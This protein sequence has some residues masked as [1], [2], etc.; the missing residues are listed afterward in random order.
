MALV[1]ARSNIKVAGIASWGIS[2]TT[3]SDTGYSLIPYL[4]N[5]KVEIKTLQTNNSLGQPVP[6]GY[7]LSASAQFPAVKTTANFIKILHHLA[8]DQIEHKIT[9]I[10]G[11][12]ISS[13]PGTSTPSPTGFGTKWRI[14][15][16]KDMDGNMYTEI[17]I[18]RR[19]TAAEYTQILTTANAPATGTSAT[20]TN[21]LNLTRADIVPA[22]ISSV[23]L[24]AASAGTY[25]DVISNLRNGKFTAEL[26]CTK[27]SR[28]Q[29]MGY[30]VKVDFDI[31]G[32]ETAETEL[33][34]TVKWEDIVMRANE[35]KITFANTM[36]IS[37]P[38]Q[39]GI[40]V[41]VVVDKDSDDIA[42][43]RISGSGI[44]VA[45]AFDALWT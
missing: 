1:P 7:E 16:D 20:F 12:I 24:G 8:S 2:S 39:L 41:S 5:G 45:S 27:D 37:L 32:M 4:Q 30:A 42:F 19:L 22:G 14:V 38:T 18:S 28:G 34:G 9:L 40:T 36:V 44:I 6:Y 29:D 10:N 31:E 15:S 35:C 26:L 33:Y 25:A 17:S 11:Q 21:F 13:N 3:A 43:L 23:A